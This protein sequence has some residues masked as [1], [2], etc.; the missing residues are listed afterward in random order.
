HDHGYPGVDGA[1]LADKLEPAPARHLLVEQYDA[2]G[3]ATQQREGVVAVRRRCDGE[4]LGLEKEKVGGEPLHFVVHPENGLG[5]RH[6]PKLMATGEPGQRRT[7]F[8]ACCASSSSGSAPSAISCSPRRS[9]A[10][11]PAATPRPSS[12]S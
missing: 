12:C 9:C 4:P 10:R 6:R 3:L 2:V 11:S 8:A 5:P 7:Y 1:D